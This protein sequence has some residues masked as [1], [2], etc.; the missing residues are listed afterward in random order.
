MNINQPDLNLNLMDYD[1]TVWNLDL[2]DDGMN[3]L[4]NGDGSCMFWTDLANYVLACKR[5]RPLFLNC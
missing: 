3:S 5:K 4:M 2:S 1:I